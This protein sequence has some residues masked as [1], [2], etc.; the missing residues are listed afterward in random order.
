MYTLLSTHGL[1]CGV[2]CLKKGSIYSTTEHLFFL[3]GKCGSECG[4]C[5]A[6]VNVTIRRDGKLCDR[7]SERIKTRH[8]RSN[9]KGQ[10]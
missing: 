10:V 7:T 3:R 9:L 5:S 4:R 6:L 1:C 8:L 2:Y